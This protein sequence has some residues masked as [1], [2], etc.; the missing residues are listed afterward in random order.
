MTGQ[1]GF[2][3]AAASAAEAAVAAHPVDRDDQFGLAP[4]DVAGGTAQHG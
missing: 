4:H 3:A 1:L 2:A